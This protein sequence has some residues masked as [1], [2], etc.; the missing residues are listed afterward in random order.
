LS[1]SRLI[2]GFASTLAQA[3]KLILS[4]CP[5]KPLARF[6]VARFESQLEGN[7]TPSWNLPERQFANFGLDSRK[8]GL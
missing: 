5:V 2:L 8:I 3:F 1:S 7:W 4:G 6:L